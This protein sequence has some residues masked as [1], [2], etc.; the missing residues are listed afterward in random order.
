MPPLGRSRNYQSACGL[1]W[2]TLADGLPPERSVK[3]RP[4]CGPE[5]LLPFDHACLAY[6]ALHSMHFTLCTALYALRSMH[7]ALCTSLYALRSMHFILCTSLYA[8]HSMH[9]TLCTSLCAL[10]SMHFTLCTSLYALNSMYFTLCCWVRGL[11]TE[12]P[13]A[14]LSGKSARPPEKK[15]RQTSTARKLQSEE[16]NLKDFTQSRLLVV[17]GDIESLISC[18]VVQRTCPHDHAH[19]DRLQQ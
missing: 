16:H 3:L 1:L 4:F 2:Q 19:S 18:M 14:M 10:H 6:D 15:M 13:F 17:E 11:R 8:L 12:E 5:G 9:F 7:C